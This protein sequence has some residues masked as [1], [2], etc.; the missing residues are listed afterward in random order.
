MAVLFSGQNNTKQKIN[1]LAEHNL[2][3]IYFAHKLYLAQVNKF[4]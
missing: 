4:I 3:H 2:T 1:S